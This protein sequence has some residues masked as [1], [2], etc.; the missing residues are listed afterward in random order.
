MSKTNPFDAAPRAHSLCRSIAGGGDAD[1]RARK[2]RSD[3]V[4]SAQSFDFA[5]EFAKL[6]VPALNG[7]AAGMQ[8]LSQSRSQPDQAADSAS[9]MPA[10]TE[11]K[12]VSLTTALRQ[13]APAPRP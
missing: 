2:S 6:L 3:Q 5:S 4:S 7:P 10:G 13:L 12:A 9:A 8:P 11:T 1:D